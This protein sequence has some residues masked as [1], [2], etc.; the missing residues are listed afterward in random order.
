M[1]LVKLNLVSINDNL[2]SFYESIPY[3]L[4]N[5]SLWKIDIINFIHSAGEHL[6]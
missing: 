1:L 6:L 5:I 3:Y 2:R 4:E